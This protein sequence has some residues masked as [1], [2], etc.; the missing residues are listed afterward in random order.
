[1][2]EMFHSFR[3]RDYRWLW[4]MT[5]LTNAGLWTFTLVATWQAYVLT[6]SSSWSGAIMFATLIPNIVGAPIAG[7]LADLMDRRRL[8]F[9]AAIAQVGVTG[10][11]AALSHFQLT[12]PE[13]LLGLSLLF[14]FASSGL[15]VMLSSMVPEII[16]SE[17]LFNALSLQAVAQRGTEFVGPAVASPLLILNG[18]GTVYLLATVFYLAAAVVVFFLSKVEIHDESV[19]TSTRKLTFRPLLDGF[20]YIRKTPTIG[21]LVSLVGLHCALTMAYMGMLPQ[22][23]KVALHGTSAFYGEMVSTIGLGSIVG[24]LL[25]AGIKQVRVR[26]RLY[27]MTAIFSGA[28]LSLLA[29]SRNP[30]VAIFAIV[31]VG[32]SQAAFMTLSLG[33]IQ[34]MAAQNM[35]GRVTSFYLVLAGGFMSLANLGF[36]A[37]SNLYSPRFIM[38]FSG[39]LFVV[40]VIVYAAMSR[41]FRSVSRF[42]VFAPDGDVAVTV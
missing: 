7:V 40:I 18:P 29:I 15:S 5:T 41:Q 21:L 17:K 12:T 28:S 11:L 16:P 34:Q 30:L 24:T 26:G 33:Y 23:V 14:G 22:F 38:G 32:A 10:T 13:L 2:Q 42:G 31:L 35:R 39:L 37:L 6:H 3:V 20:V 8:M 9:L 1:M 27:W 36:G 25:L 19:G 4:I